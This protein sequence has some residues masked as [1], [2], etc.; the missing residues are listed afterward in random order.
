LIEYGF[1]NIDDILMDEYK[2]RRIAEAQGLS[3]IGTVGVLLQAKRKGLPE[4][5]RP[6]LDELMRHHRRISGAL[7]KKALELAGEKSI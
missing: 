6:E 7:Y 3:P 1:R 5:V 2:G 4:E